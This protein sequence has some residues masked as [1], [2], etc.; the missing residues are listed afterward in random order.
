MQLVHKSFGGPERRIPILLLH[1]LLGS[2]RNW[3]S[4]ARLLCEERP[5]FALDQRNHGQSPHSNTMDYPHMA[6]DVLRWM[7]AHAMPQAH[8]VG[9]SMG[10]KVAMLAACQHP[11]RF[12]SVVV[13][14]IAPKTYQPHLK[15]AFD[16]MARI[17]PGDHSRI[18]SVEAALEQ[19]LP[20]DPELRQFLVTNLGRNAEGMFRWQINLDGIR[21]ALPA[22]SASPLKDRQHFDGAILFLSGELSDF[23][24]EADMAAARKHFPKMDWQVIPKAGHNLHIDNRGEFARSVLRFTDRVETS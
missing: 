10:G 22:L 5:V 3:T 12:P 17:K 20:D 19:Y 15:S 21:K 2:S 9:H 11:R 18:A 14:D 1:G 23:V 13:A 24:R 6:A 4:A 16:A 8:L 7:D